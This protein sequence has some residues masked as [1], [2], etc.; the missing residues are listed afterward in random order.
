MAGYETKMAD[1][2]GGRIL[3]VGDELP[4]VRRFRFF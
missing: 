1:R 4:I 2:G 3:A